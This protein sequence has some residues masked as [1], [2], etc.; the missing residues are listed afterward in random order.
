[1]RVSTEALRRMPVNTEAVRRK[2]KGY[3]MGWQM[4]HLVVSLVAKCL[5]IEDDV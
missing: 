5:S 3:E 4:I 1:M 2:R